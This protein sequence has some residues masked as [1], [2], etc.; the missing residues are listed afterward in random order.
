MTA[1]SPEPPPYPPP[2][3]AA[4]QP[5]ESAVA[6]G[7]TLHR[8]FSA[9][10]D[11][12]YF[13]RGA[14]GRLNAPSGAGYGVLY[15]AKAPQGA[16]AETFLRNPGLTLLPTDLL[17]RKAYVRLEV[18]RPLKLVRLAGPGL[19]RLGATAQVVHGGKPYDAPQ[20][21]SAALHAHPGAFDGIAYN[22]RHDDEA[23]CYAIFD[24]AADALREASRDRELDRDW[25]WDL[26]EPYGV[27][28]A[29]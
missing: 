20:A 6:A 22:A 26:A 10:H 15:A 5:L 25:F 12:I 9:A 13:D 7:E 11:P 14:D 23:L 2:D 21:W 16:F 1:A 18:L 27:G 24:R 3:L 8:F 17:A 28:L 29:P 19:A 4:R